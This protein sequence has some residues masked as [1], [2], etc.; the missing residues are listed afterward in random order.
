[1]VQSS[2]PT[3]WVQAFAVEESQIPPQ[4]AKGI[5]G[6]ALYRCLK[7]GRVDADQYLKWATEHYQMPRLNSGFF[8]LESQERA[9]EVLEKYDRLMPWSPELVP[10]SEFK[11]TLIVGALEPIE[12]L[13]KEIPI[14]TVLV[15]LKDLERW[16]RFLFQQSQSESPSQES[17]KQDLPDSFFE[18]DTDATDKSFSTTSV[19]HIS[20]Q[21]RVKDLQE[22]E[23]AIPDKVKKLN[24][25]RVTTAAQA[26]PLS[27]IA[28]G[29]Y[30]R[31]KPLYT[32]GA[33][34]EP[35]GEG[36]RITGWSSAWAPVKDLEKITIETSQ[37]SAFRIAHRTKRPFHGPVSM[38]ELNRVFFEI[39]L[40]EVPESPFLTL[41]PII[42]P[43][44]T[45]EAIFAAYSE[46]NEAAKDFEASLKLCQKIGQKIG[47]KSGLLKPPK[48][49]QPTTARLG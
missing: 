16:H 26:S 9:L 17:E 18:P 6:S 49:A 23:S 24:F 40:K 11:G 33:L 1:M 25:E 22:L 7:T 4:G 12:S 32:H 42:G 35:R 15:H 13:P 27:K 34:L 38:N 36:F 20:T 45:V 46:D 29:Y 44:L 28:T 3:P 30:S 48:V 39:F 2:S 19:T 47:L 41:V 37:P 8:N 14:Q 5:R 10:L 31:L 21:K 43:S